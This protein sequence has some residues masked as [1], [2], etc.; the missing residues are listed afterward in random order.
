MNEKEVNVVAVI[1][2]LIKI[3]AT[4]TTILKAIKKYVNM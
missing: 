4:T 2:D 1:V 3:T